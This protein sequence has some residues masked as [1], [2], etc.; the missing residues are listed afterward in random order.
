M[1]KKEFQRCGDLTDSRGIIASMN[2][3]L[4]SSNFHYQQDCG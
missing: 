4:E 3:A 1:E 2:G